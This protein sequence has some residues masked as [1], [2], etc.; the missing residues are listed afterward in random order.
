MIRTG[1][2]VLILATTFY[3]PRLSAQASSAQEST[4]LKVEL[5]SAT[6]SH[7][8]HL[9]EAIP[10]E[11]L[12]S[13]STPNRYLEPC[14]MFRESCFGFPH[15]RYFT[16]WSFEVTPI[17]GWT[18]V[19]GHGCRAMSGPSF[20]LKSSDLTIEP[21]KYAYTLTNRFRFD[22]PGK[23]TVRLSITLGLDD[24]TNAIGR[25]LDAKQ[26]PHFVKK[27]AEM[28]LEIVPAEDQRKEHP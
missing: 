8:F 20:D 25:S 4:D 7:R 26:N 21:K 16:R 12:I 15:C 9:G 3:G 11:V 19:G 22:S 10:L 14:T 2:T 17:H 23:Y 24:E 13:S 1:L 6:G 18:D 27:M 5:R 28:E